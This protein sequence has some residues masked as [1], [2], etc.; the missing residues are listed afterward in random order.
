M[1]DVVINESHSKVMNYIEE[2]LEKGYAAVSLKLWM[3]L[4]IGKIDLDI[5]EIGLTDR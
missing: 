4:S 1:R 5:I 2:L 3:Q